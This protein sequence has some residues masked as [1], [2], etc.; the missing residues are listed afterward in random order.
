MVSF[1]TL[2]AGCGLLDMFEAAEQ[3]PLEVVEEVPMQAD[4]AAL[5]VPDQAPMDGADI[6]SGGLKD[7]PREA[8]DPD[9]PVAVAPEDWNPVSTPQGPREGGGVK[10]KGVKTMPKGDTLQELGITEEELEADPSL[11]PS[12][13]NDTAEE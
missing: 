6:A 11:R 8:P 7:P 1:V 4:P 13:L 12:Q 5:E 3:E 2:L 10:W 9:A